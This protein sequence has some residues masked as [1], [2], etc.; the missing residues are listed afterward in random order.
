MTFDHCTTQCFSDG[1]EPTFAGWNATFVAN[2]LSVAGFLPLDEM[3]A[4][5]KHCYGNTT[6][7]E[8]LEIAIENNSGFI[9]SV[10]IRLI[11]LRLVYGLGLITYRRALKGLTMRQMIIRGYTTTIRPSAL[12]LLETM[13]AM[14]L[15]MDWFTIAHRFTIA[16]MEFW[17]KLA[18]CS[19][20][21]Q[22]K[23]TRK[24]HRNILRKYMCSTF[25]G[26][27][28]AGKRYWNDPAPPI[29]LLKQGHA[30]LKEQFAKHQQAQVPRVVP[31]VSA[32]DEVIIEEP[33]VEEPNIEEPNGMAVDEVII[34]EAVD[35]IR[36]LVS[37]EDIAVLEEDYD[38]DSDSESS[39]L[40]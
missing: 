10:L 13:H 26:I 16:R 32:D 22:I 8:H 5:V 27:K 38:W 20:L 34:E 1:L 36:R 40:W 23:T 33:I 29:V 19:I 12:R 2:V 15:N 31:T 3:Q 35:E 30:F 6:I 14:D 4:C 25:E 28:T 11:I 21:R 9:L 18:E 7:T 17:N 39:D 37:Q 24:L